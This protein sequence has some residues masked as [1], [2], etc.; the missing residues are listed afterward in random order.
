MAVLFDLGILGPCERVQG[1]AGDGGTGVGIR[2]ADD[3]ILYRLIAFR[4][5]G[6]FF[7][8]D[9]RCFSLCG[10]FRRGFNINL[11]DLFLSGNEIICRGYL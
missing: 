11:C 3:G 8:G 10:S 4:Q 5:H 7:L 1:G 9:Y 6:F 2:G